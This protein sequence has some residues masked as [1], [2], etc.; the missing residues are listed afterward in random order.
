MGMT[1]GIVLIEVLVILLFHVWHGLEGS[2]RQLHVDKGRAT[3][4]LLCKY[5]ALFSVRFMWFLN[6][7]V[8]KCLHFI[9]MFSYT[10]HYSSVAA[11]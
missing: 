1:F 9:L 11:V 8:L 7:L 3:Q 10:F 4:D 2:D 6:F 5:V